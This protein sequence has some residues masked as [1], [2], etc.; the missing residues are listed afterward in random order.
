MR[1]FIRST[2]LA[3]LLI[4]TCLPVGA[5]TPNEFYTTLLRRGVAAYDA[6]RY[7][8]AAR[9]LRFAAFGLVEAVDQYQV[10]QIYLAL[11]YDKIGDA[12][13]ARDAARKVAVAERVERRFGALTLPASVRSAFDTIATRVLS[14]NDIATLRAAVVNP[15]AA[16]PQQPQTATVTPPRTTTTT[17]PRTTT[18]ST[19][20][21]PA[22]PAPKTQEITI[23]APLTT[24]NTTT[25][26]TPRPSTSAPP[27][28]S[29]STQPPKPTP[30]PATKPAVTPP[31]RTTTTQTPG[32]GGPV[33]PARPATTPAPRPLTASE[34]TARLSVAERALNA[35]NLV[36]A[37]RVYRELLTQPALGRD[38]M[39]RVAEG[40]YRARDFA[41][42][43]NAFTRIGTLRR[44]EEPYRYYIAVA[45][46]ETGD[47][48]RAKR[49]L[50][51]ALPY[52]EIT[53]DVARY[54]SRIEGAL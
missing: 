44:G 45:A 17:P 32:R 20:P 43:L 13:R 50:A 38:A 52:I 19:T 25:K 11:T 7:S 4:G 42:A 35:A 39:I 16:Q 54:R 8:D 49:E 6:S 22:T 1:N 2:T 31:P 28:S 40:L 37:R 21:K 26:P 5:A 9:Q 34:A 51:A 47:H 48:A 29:A 36:E 41:G 23:P 10:A 15:P 33:E 14:P 18:T 53:P 27:T 12:E 46:Y 30:A 24:D 3:V